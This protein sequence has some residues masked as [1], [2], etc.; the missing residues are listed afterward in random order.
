MVGVV[1]T[2]VGDVVQDFFAIETIPLRHGQHT[3]RAEC[4][5]SVDVKALAL[6]TSH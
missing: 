5:F 3:H 4:T 2:R 1:G 6:S